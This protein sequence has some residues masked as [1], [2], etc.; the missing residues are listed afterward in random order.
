MSATEAEIAKK[1]GATKW[2]PE[3]RR[4]FEVL[5][6]RSTPLGKR[7]KKE[8]F[9]REGNAATRLPRGRCEAVARQRLE[10][11]F[12]LRQRFQIFRVKMMTGIT[13]LIHDDLRSHRRFS[14]V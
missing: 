6:K 12:G 11:A 7:L 13:C 14:T 10:A 3:Q 8:D 2:S 9:D 4:E 5:T 1:H